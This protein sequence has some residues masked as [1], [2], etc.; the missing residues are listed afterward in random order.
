MLPVITLDFA[1]LC[2]L[3]NGD[4]F[5]RERIQIR[6]QTYAFDAQ[7]V[8]RVG[9]VA[10]FLSRLVADGFARHPLK[11][12]VLICYSATASLVMLHVC[13]RRRV[14]LSWLQR[15]TELESAP[16]HVPPQAIPCLWWN[17][18]DLTRLHP[19]PAG[20]LPKHPR[21]EDFGNPLGVVSEQVPRKQWEQLRMDIWNT[22][23]APVPMQETETSEGIVLKHAFFRVE[24]EAW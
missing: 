5:G 16:T 2:G 18:S 12:P 9:T 20:E 23:Y 21:V 19:L 4:F 17:G 22:D 14:R 13:S 10:T 8:L 24:E 15:A 11:T 6:A 1:A 3:D 7:K